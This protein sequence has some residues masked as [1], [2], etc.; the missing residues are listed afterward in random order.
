[1]RGSRG[2]Y[3][4]KRNKTVGIKRLIEVAI[5]ME[6]LEDSGFEFSFTYFGLESDSKAYNNYLAQIVDEF[7]AEIPN[8][9]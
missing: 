9:H 7:L 8:V 6:S 2:E 1:L 3:E 4:I 5:W